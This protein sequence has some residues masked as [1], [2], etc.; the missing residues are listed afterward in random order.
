MSLILVNPPL[1]WGG[2]RK[3]VAYLE[4]IRKSYDP[5]DVGDFA[6]EH[7]GLASIQAYCRKQG[8]PVHVVN[9]LLAEHTTVEE[10]FADIQAVAA[11]HGT[12]ALIGFSGTAQVWKATLPLI[13]MCKAAWP[14]VKTILGYDFGTLNFEH[15]LTH[16]PLVDYICQGEGERLYHQVGEA[17]AAGRTPQHIAGLAWRGEDGK[18]ESLP[19]DPVDLDTLPWPTRE[20]LP[21]VIQKG[22]GAGVYTSRGCPYRCTYCATGATSALMSGKAGYRLRAVENVVDELEY[23]QRDF[24]LQFVGILDDLFLTSS[25]SSHARAEAF[26]SEILKRGLKMRWMCDSRLD[27]VD[28]G[29]F[30]HLNAAGLAKVYM[31]VETGSTEQL[32]SYNKKF[33]LRRDLKKEQPSEVIRKMAEVGVRVCP[34]IIMWHPLITARELRQTLELID[35]CGWHSMT[36]LWNRIR[37]YPGTPLYKQYKDLGLLTEGEWPLENWTFPDPRYKEMADAVLFHA[38]KPGVDYE[39]TK[40]VFLKYLE[41]IEGAERA[42]ATPVRTCLPVVGAS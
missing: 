24:G 41:Q 22:F 27:S 6:G 37:A 30:K 32:L 12:P 39:D 7:I 10:T 9:G 26:A 2:A 19:P 1:F 36:S 17:L 18:I 25:P 14:D 33:T 20:Q 42:A 38:V 40:R 34:G 5:R 28:I 31:G 16:F 23:L 4:T 35:S 15:L 29:L 8:L 3:R 13:A 21:L 11:Q